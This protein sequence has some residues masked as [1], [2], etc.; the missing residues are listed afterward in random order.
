VVLAIPGDCASTRKAMLAVVKI[1]DIRLCKRAATGP[2][3]SRI[4]FALALTQPLSARLAP[5]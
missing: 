4:A 2:R 5:R 3:P 1:S